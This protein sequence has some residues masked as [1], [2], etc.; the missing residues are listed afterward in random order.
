MSITVS[1]NAR[2]AGGL[3]SS[4][5]ASLFNNSSNNL[6]SGLGMM[7]GFSFSDYASI[8]NGSYHKL[9]S[10]YYAL[11]DSD[12]DTKTGSGSRTSASSSTTRTYNYWT[13]DGMVQR[14]YDLSNKTRPKTV[15]STTATSKDK[16]STLATIESDAEKLKSASDTLLTS[17]AK[18]LF[19]QE[20]MTDKD[21]NKTTGYNTDAIYKAVNNY[22]NSYNS[23]VK[24]AGGSKVMA[25]R[26]SAASIMDYTKSNQALLSSVGITLD[27]EKKTLSIDEKAFKEAD[28]ETVKKLFQ[29]TNSYAYKV[30]QK[31]ASIDSHAQ[32]E[33]TKASTYNGVGTYSYNYSSGSVLNGTI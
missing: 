30:S 1:A 4:M 2:M 18:S 5:N 33:A 19:K 3:F 20:T 9:L 29:G 16:T 10:S 22:V 6:Y 27:A 25:I 13:P 12:S 15:N 32:Y 24:S 17:G 14:T 31:A 8:R 21:G 23:L 26:T 7:G 28:M 11:G